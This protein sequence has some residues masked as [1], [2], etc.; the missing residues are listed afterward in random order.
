MAWGCVAGSVSGSPVLSENAEPCLGHSISH[1][2][3][4]T[5][6]SASEASAWEQRSSRAY[7]SSPMRTTA[8]RQPSLSTRM[9][10]P[11]AT[12]PTLQTTISG[13]RRFLLAP[14][15]PIVGVAAAPGVELPGDSRPQ[16]LLGAG[17]EGQAV[18]GVLEEAEH[19]EPLG[20]VG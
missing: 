5:S 1:S 19:D 11:G 2:S 7:Q 18:A 14:V 4:H 13:I 9:A 10:D 20:H 17:A 15:P 8:S 3:P 16:P 6:P 12:S